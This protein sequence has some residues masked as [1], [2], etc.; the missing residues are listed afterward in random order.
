MLVAEALAL[1][2]GGGESCGSACK[3]ADAE[4][5]GDAEPVEDA[6]KE[7]AADAPAA[8]PTSAV[9]VADVLA[10]GEGGGGGACD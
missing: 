2:D 10:L 3:D 1:G 5:D 7:A 6:D 4:P 9:L 8:I